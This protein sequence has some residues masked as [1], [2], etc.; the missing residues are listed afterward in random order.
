MDFHPHPWGAVRKSPL[1]YP[2]QL[3]PHRRGAAD[4]PRSL[5]DC[6]SRV[7]E[8]GRDS[9]GRVRAHRHVRDVHVLVLHLHEAEVLLGLHLAGRRELRDRAACAMLRLCRPTGSI[10]AVVAVALEAWPP[11]LE[12]TSVS[13]TRILMFFWHLLTGLDC[14]EASI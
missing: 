12:C 2:S 1:S 3:R 9:L 5:C 4:V 8:T 14:P 7:A 11:V 10:M 13:M 6:R